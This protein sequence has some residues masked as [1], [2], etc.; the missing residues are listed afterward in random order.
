MVIKNNQSK[1]LLFSSLLF[2]L[3]FDNYITP[4]G[5]R[6]FDLFGLLILAISLSVGF[7]RLHYLWRVKPLHT[8]VV[9]ISII[10]LIPAGVFIY[11][12]FAFIPL[13]SGVALFFLLINS[14]EFYLRF[15]CIIKYGIALASGALILQFVIYL[16]TGDLPSFLLLAT[17]DYT[18][19]NFAGLIM[20]PTGFYIEPGSHALVVVTLLMIYWTKNN[21]RFDLLST[22]ASISIVLSMSFAGLMALMVALLIIVTKKSLSNILRIS[23]AMLVLASLVVVLDPKLVVD[24]AD[25][26]FVQRFDTILE[27]SDGSAN[28]RIAKL[29]QNCIT[30]VYENNPLGLFVGSGITSEYFTPYCGA[31]NIAW[32]IFNYGLFVPLMFIGPLLWRFRKSPL[33]LWAILYIAFS[34][35]LSSYMFIWLYFALLVGPLSRYLGHLSGVRPMLMTKI[36]SS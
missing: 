5:V 21:Y 35:Q 29:D 23:A 36:I 20:R 17:E 3:F 31:N 30:F 32:A 24:T 27:G 7:I 28:D 6:V 10:Y 4:P 9:F 22:I 2:I 11:N 14:K 34:G 26:V 16:I 8:L 12:S 33:I 18:R 13:L 15:D 25:F 1:V 19:S